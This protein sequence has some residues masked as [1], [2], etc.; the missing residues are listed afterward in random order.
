ML[1]NFVLVLARFPTMPVEL[2]IG[3]LKICEN[4]RS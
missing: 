1:A 2:T 3:L 4:L